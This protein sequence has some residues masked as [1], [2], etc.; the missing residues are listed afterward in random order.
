MIYNHILAC[1]VGATRARIA[2]IDAHGNVA[3]KKVLNSVNSSPSIL[4]DMIIQVL[5]ESKLQ[6]DGGV[7]GV[8]GPV[9]YESGQIIA[10]PNLDSWDG[11][12]S[13][14]Y[15]TSELQFE[16]LI[17]ND[18]DLAALG[19]HGFGAGLGFSN[20]V[21]I[22]VSTGIG[23][24]IIVNDRLLKGRTSLGEIGHTII[25]RTNLNTLEKLASGASLK[26][27]TG[28]PADE[29]VKHVRE[30]NLEYLGIF[31]EFTRDLS[32]G[33]YNLCRIFSPDTVVIGGGLSNAGPLLLNPIR[34]FLF[35]NLNL[36]GKVP[37]VLSIAKCGDD[38]GLIGARV[39][40]NNSRSNYA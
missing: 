29:V 2:I 36:H 6:V 17:A 38:S 30:K 39:F 27:I 8:A 3:H 26:K 1:D 21:Y 31:R 4:I 40:W 10:L 13:S 9:D 34:D 28:L 15:L 37:I 5:K 18:A 23:S 11:L 7:V 24:G 16:V 14:D 35:E 33:I 19:E 22:T 12:L 32:I 25:D 20:M